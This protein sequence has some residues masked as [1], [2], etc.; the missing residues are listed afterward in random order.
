MRALASI[1]PKLPAEITN[2]DMLKFLA[3]LQLDEQPAIRTNTTIALGKLSNQLNEQTRAKV[4]LPAFSRGLR[5]PFPPAR[6]SALAA[7]LATHEFYSPHDCALRILPAVAG[8]ALEADPALRELALAVVRK[9]VLTL[10]ALQPALDAQWQQGQTAAPVAAPSENKSVLGW[11]SK[12]LQASPEQPPS[13]VS[14]S[15]LP[16]PNR[17]D[18][19]SLSQ[20]ASG[21]EPASAK[22]RLDANAFATGWDE[23]DSADAWG[24]SEF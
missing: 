2:G 4:L 5:D 1:A 7:L 3:R 11:A 17:P 19:V 21:T 9:C 23:Q 14:H 10:E 15:S 12:W 20:R 16:P 18:P 13:S 6:R 24:D 22:A 8:S